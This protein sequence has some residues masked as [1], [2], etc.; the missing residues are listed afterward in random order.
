MKEAPRENPSGFPRKTSRRSK[1]AEA[2]SG[3][4]EGYAQGC[5]LWKIALE[6][7]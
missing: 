1:K 2:A 4:F 6:G 3:R 7:I 5:S